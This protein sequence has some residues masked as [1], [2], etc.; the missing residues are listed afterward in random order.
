MRYSKSTGIS[1]A[2]AARELGDDPVAVVGVHDR[3][4]NSGS[5][6]QR[7]GG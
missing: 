1:V 5:S 2:G 4:Q 7:S 6:V 3:A